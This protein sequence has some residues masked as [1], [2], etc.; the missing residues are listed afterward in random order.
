ML[1]GLPTELRILHDNILNREKSILKAKKQAYPVWTVMVPEGFHFVDTPPADK[2]YV[3]FDEIFNLFHL[4]MLYPSLLRLSALHQA[5]LAKADPNIDVAVADP[6]L[7]HDGTMR[8]PAGRKAVT[9]Y[10]EKLMLANRD[11]DCIIL[12]YRP[13]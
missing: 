8:T 11:K 5:Y 10:I 4:R 13:S 6:Y 9:D 3:R 1:E 2:F 12:P 7:M